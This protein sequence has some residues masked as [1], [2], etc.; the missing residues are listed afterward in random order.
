MSD[1]NE[2]L[3]MSDAIVNRTVTA[4]KGTQRDNRDLQASVLEHRLRHVA[5][6]VTILA[7]Y[8]SQREI[9]DLLE[10]EG[11][12]GIPQGTVSKLTAIGEF[13][14]GDAALNADTE[15]DTT[16]AERA[17]NAFADTLNFVEVSTNA[18]YHATRDGYAIEN[19]T[20]PDEIIAALNGG[21]KP[22]KVDTGDSSKTKQGQGYSKVLKAAIEELRVALGGT[23]VT[24]D[25]LG[26]FIGTTAQRLTLSK[27][28]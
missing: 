8:G 14:I 10:S 15:G 16:V 6:F 4:L 5:P 18:L 9:A 19:A 13:F 11:V 22:A 24:D 3:T 20:T 23:E 1:P 25:D 28:A 27:A 26:T 21:A 7:A 17:W 2:R 12:K